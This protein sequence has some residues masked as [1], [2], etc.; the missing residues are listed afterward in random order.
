MEKD[1]VEPAVIKMVKVS[2]R[3]QRYEVCV[4]KEG[5]MDWMREDIEVVTGENPR[6]PV[7]VVLNNRTISIFEANH[8]DTIAW[9]VNLH[10]ID[11]IEEKAGD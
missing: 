5:D 7:R 9:S 8:Y 1:I 3:K 2:N 4:I 6:F 11:R 10:T